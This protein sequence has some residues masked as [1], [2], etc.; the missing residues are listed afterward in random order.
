MFLMMFFFLSSLFHNRIDL[1]HWISVKISD[2]QAIIEF[3]L[4]SQSDVN[5]FNCFFKNFLIV[6]LFS[7][8]KLSNLS[9]RRV[10]IIYVFYWTWRI[11]WVAVFVILF[12]FLNF[13][14]LFIICRRES[15]W[16]QYFDLLLLFSLYLL[17]FV[18]SNCILYLNF[19]FLFILFHHW[20]YI[21]IKFLKHGRTKH[22][23][24]R[25]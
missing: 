3:H 18:N 4:M 13:L 24:F 17:L 16:L 2:K 22:Q 20:I 21:F 12:K 8:I 23:I 10:I 6:N 11:V 1:R 15:R 9:F 14:N 19:S 5:V 7:W 25:C